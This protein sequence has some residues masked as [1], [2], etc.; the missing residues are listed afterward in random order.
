VS[1]T[2]RRHVRKYAKGDLGTEKSFYFRSPDG[3]LNLRAQNLTMFVQI[4]EG[5]DDETWDFHRRR[6]DY[7]RWTGDS[8]KDDSLAWEVERIE[9]GDLPTAEAKRSIREA[10]ER[11]YKLP[12]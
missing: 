8:I 10:L 5:V 4:A 3:R 1:I 7:S 6:G 12:G 2:H 11:R 9:A